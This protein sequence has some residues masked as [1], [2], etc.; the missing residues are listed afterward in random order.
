M[1]PRV[2]ALSKI[3]LFTIDLPVNSVNGAKAGKSSILKDTN[4]MMALPPALIPACLL[5]CL[6]A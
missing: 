3:D 4:E 5:K 1:C 6:S 2:I